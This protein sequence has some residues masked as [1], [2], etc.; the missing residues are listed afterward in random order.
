MMFNKKSRILPLLEN[1]FLSK[2]FGGCLTLGNKELNSRIPENSEVIRFILAKYC[3][4]CTQFTNS[5]A[6]DFDSKIQ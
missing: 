3:I 5:A 4:N 2:S 6:S 1:A